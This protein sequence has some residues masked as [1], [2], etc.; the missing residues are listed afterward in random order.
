MTEGKGR[1]SDK[2]KCPMPN[3]RLKATFVSLVAEEFIHPVNGIAGR[4]I[5]VECP[6]HGKRLVTSTGRPVTSHNHSTRK[7]SAA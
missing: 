3:C 1:D 7:G 6:N 4:H 2:F 5:I